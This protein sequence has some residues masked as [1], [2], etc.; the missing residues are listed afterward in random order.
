M[1]YADANSTTSMPPEVVEA[2]TG[3]INRGDP[4]EAGRRAREATEKL[5]EQ[6]QEQTESLSGLAA[7][8]FRIIHVSSAAEANVA[9]IEACVSAY[10][11]S[12]GRSPHV[13]VG[14]AEPYSILSCVQRLYASRRC[15]VS[16]AAIDVTAGAPTPDSVLTCIR[17]NTCLV[18]VS[19]ANAHTGALAHLQKIGL[20]CYAEASA[21]RRGHKAERRRIPLHSDLSLFYPRTTTPLEMLMLDAF[22]ISAHHMHAPPGFGCLAVR[23]GL[24]QGYGLQAI[25]SGR[26]LNLPGLAATCIAQRLSLENRGYKNAQ[27]AECVGGIVS[28]LQSM[29]H[30]CS[31]PGGPRLPPELKKLATAHKKEGHSIKAIES[32]LGLTN[33]EPSEPTIVFLGP[34]PARRLPNTILFAVWGVDFSGSE[35]QGALEEGDPPVI[36][37][38]FGK[39]DQAVLSALQIPSCLHRCIL[40]VSLP[41]GTSKKIAQGLVSCLVGTIASLT[42]ASQASGSPP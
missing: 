30:T 18:T 33:C 40:R 23:E 28:V 10:W 4:L 26:M 42:G 19:G 31:Y 17:Q 6:F 3:A 9:I 39:E 2:W 21:A 37:R 1:I 12:S 16:Y 15:T 38:G 7:G 24:V 32:G 35:L 29:C 25:V 27:L 5:L 13:V 36:A 8:E 14:A 20:I 11:R 41:D 34:P 22:S